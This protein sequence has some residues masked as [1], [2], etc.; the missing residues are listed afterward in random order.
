MFELYMEVSE[1]TGA[2]GGGR[3]DAEGADVEAGAEV[4]V[5]AGEQKKMDPQILEPEP[6][7]S[8]EK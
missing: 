1:G 6:Y 4:E 8:L 2:D 7:G 5:G 3:V